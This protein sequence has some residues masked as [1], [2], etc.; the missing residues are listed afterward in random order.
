MVALLLEVEE[1]PVVERDAILTAIREESVPAVKRVPGFVSGTW[2]LGNGSGKWLAL[3]LFDTAAHAQGTLDRLSDHR[4]RA[5][6]GGPIV[7]FE[8]REIAATA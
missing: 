6:T 5:L 4:G 2:V 3:I 7:R 1:E 8:V